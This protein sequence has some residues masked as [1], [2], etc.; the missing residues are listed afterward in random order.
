M[1]TLKLYTAGDIN[2]ITN[3][4]SGET[5]L[6]E[7]VQTLT[8]LELLAL[9]SSKFVLLGLP[10]D[11]GIKANFGITGSR[12]AWDQA[13]KSLMNIQST[14]KLR[15][16]E[17]TVLGHIDFSDKLDKA[18][19]LNP[20]QSEDLKSLR[21]LVSEIDEE[22]EEVIR[23]IYGAG[24]IPIVI[25]GGHNNSYPILKGFSKFFNVPVNTINLDAHSDF[26]PLEG[27]HSGN[28]FS[29]AFKKGFLNKYS[30]IGLH[31]NYNSQAIIDEFKSQP[32]HFQYVFLEDFLRETTSYSRAFQ[33]AMNFTDG[34]C[35][36][37]IDVDCIAGSLASAM[38][39]CGFTAEQVRDMIA[40]TTIRQFFYLHI[41]EAAHR[42][43]EGQ[44]SNQ[45][46][47]LI[48]YL[49][50]DFMKAQL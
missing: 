22:V 34:L 13:I 25:G 37:E 46:G 19:S 42:L 27:R 26:R 11:I 6:G 44:E 40:Q 23:M 16:D 15:G 32:K 35:G 14:K 12:T 36:L 24:K 41:A 4:R 7:K 1:E 21:Q 18:R 47:K 38:S 20:R 9:S 50:S 3:T 5:K 31:E 28:G 29:Y 33:D 49:I 30:V 39:P 8:D 17:I 10:E 43:D 48:A 45:T 2:A